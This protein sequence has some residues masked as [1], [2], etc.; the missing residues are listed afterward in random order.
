[1]NKFA[2]IKHIQSIGKVHYY[3]IV[4]DNN[5]KSLFEDFN[6]YHR[7]D[8]WLEDLLIMNNWLIKRIPKEGALEKYF[9]HEG[10]RSDTK[11]LPPKFVETKNLLRLYCFRASTNVVF[12]FNGRCK[13]KSIVKAQDCPVVRPHFLLA[14]EIVI[15]LNN[16]F[17]E[18]LIEWNEDYTDIIFDEE[19]TF[20]IE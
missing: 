3:S 10:I 7:T 17:S 2:Q 12:L 15:A 1:V 11:G 4:I 9:R 13:T 19:L 8:K 5:E 14:N 6:D 20:E 18:D 16:L